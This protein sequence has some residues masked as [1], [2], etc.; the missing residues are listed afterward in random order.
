MVFVDNE[1]AGVA[2]SQAIVIREELAGSIVAGKTGEF[3]VTGR[4][5]VAVGTEHARITFTGH[6][7]AETS[8]DQGLNT[9]SLGS[10]GLDVRL[11]FL[12]KEAA[13]AYVPSWGTAN[14][15]LGYD[16]DGVLGE[17]DFPEGTAG[18]HRHCRAGA[19]GR[20][21]GRLV[22]GCSG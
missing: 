2:D 13:T 21:R 3:I 6:L 19:H 18:H 15:P 20:L 1:D 7:S 12:H 11:H 16:A 4:T 9:F 5:V 10:V 17:I 8:I 14:T 22:G